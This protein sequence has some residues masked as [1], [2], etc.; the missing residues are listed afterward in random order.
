MVDLDF[1]KQEAD[2]LRVSMDRAYI[3]M[4]EQL[5]AGKDA[6]SARAYFH[7]TVEQHRAVIAQIAEQ[8]GLVLDARKAKNAELVKA[9][10]DK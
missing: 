6:T 5:D 1:L 10:F 4:R 8:R 2:D 9:M 7:A 3:R